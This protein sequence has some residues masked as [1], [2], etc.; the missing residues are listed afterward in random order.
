MHYLDLK[1]RNCNLYGP[2][3]LAEET[4]GDQTSDVSA[5]KKIHQV[6]KVVAGAELDEGLREQCISRML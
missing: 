5:L 4:V 6:G 2:V 3:Q 1:T